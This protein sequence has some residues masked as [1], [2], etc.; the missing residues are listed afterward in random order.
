MTAN[1]LVFPVCAVF[2]VL[3]LLFFLFVWIR[4]WVLYWQTVQAAERLRHTEHYSLG[5]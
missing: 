2:S 5:E 1:D 3:P 4:K